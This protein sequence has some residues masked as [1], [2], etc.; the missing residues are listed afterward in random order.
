MA[1]KYATALRN[2][3]LDAVTSQAGTSARLRI[4]NGTRPANPNTAITSQTMLVELTCNATAFAAAASGG[5][6]TA[7]AISNG[8]AAATGTAS[9]FRLWQSNGTTPVIDG[10]VGTSGSDLN[11]NN[12]SIATGQTV[13]VTSFAITDGNA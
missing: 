6:L 11:L 1:I 13:S 8:T 3:Q 7:N 5:V 9:W 2:A 12:T 10:D 4:Y